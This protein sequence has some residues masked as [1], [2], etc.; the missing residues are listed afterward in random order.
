MESVV[1]WNLTENTIEGMDFTQLFQDMVEWLEFVS[2][3]KNVQ[4]P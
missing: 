2:T 1:K 4:I 3:V